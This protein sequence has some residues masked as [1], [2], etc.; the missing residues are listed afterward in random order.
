MPTQV[1]H[2]GSRS[3]LSAIAPTTRIGPRVSSPK[4]AITPAQAMKVRYSGTACAYCRDAIAS[5]DQVSAPSTHAAESA[6]GDPTGRWLSRW[7]TESVLR[8]AGF[9]RALDA[10]SGKRVA[11]G[12]EGDGSSGYLQL[13]A[14]AS[15][16][17]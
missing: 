14:T 10:V 8:R 11:R 6:A 7:T 4:S 2:S 17:G 13:A 5:S 3:G 12:T 15:S 16:T 1:A 9:V